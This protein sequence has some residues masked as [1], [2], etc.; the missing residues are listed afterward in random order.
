MVYLAKNGFWVF[1]SYAFT[2]LSGFFLVIVMTKI[3]S[4][5]TYGLYIYVIS[6]IN[7]LQL[8]TLPGMTAA[9]TQAISRGYEGSLSEAI[10]LKIYGGLAGTLAS[11][12]LSLCYYFSNQL[13]LAACFASI[14][15]IF[16]FINSFF[17]YET[18]LIGRGLFKLNSEYKI[19]IRI[20]TVL[21][22]LVVLLFSKNIIA[23]LIATFLSLSLSGLF[24]FLYTIKKYKPNKKIDDKTIPYG[25]HLSAIQAIKFLGDNLG[26]IIIFHFFGAA[27]L[28]VYALALMPIKK[29][30]DL[31]AL[32]REMSLPK[33]SQRP[34][35][36]I[37]KN[38]T[39]KIVK[40]SFVWLFIALIYLLAA[41]TI[42]KIFFPNYAGSVIFSQLLILTIVLLPYDFY[43]VYFRAKMKKNLLYIVNIL[44]PALKLTLF[45]VLIP[46]F[47]IMGAVISII[48]SETIIAGLN[49]F[50]FKKY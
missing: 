22:P 21:I 34:D 40:F 17:D 46:R 10:K 3:L 13:T 48:A 16:P 39:K 12:I 23:T 14:G 28:A 27:N 29:L 19:V 5:E 25:L 32:I 20:I 7:I 15:L 30:Q 47:Q 41:P 38:L 18:L 9:L 43:P 50:L 36:I 4:Q 24:F 35:E 26:G 44:G 33:L 6:I 31:N 2:L 1:L 8:S 11:L 45:F 49:Y 42:Y 37:K